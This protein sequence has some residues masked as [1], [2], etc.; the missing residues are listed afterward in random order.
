MIPTSCGHF[1]GYKEHGRFCSFCWIWRRF[2]N[3]NSFFN[4]RKDVE[5]EGEEE[6]DEGEPKDSVDL[7]G[8]DPVVPAGAIVQKIVG[9]IIRPAATSDDETADDD[10]SAEIEEKWMKK[11]AVAEKIDREYNDALARHHN[12]FDVANRIDI[13]ALNS[14]KNKQRKALP[15][16]I[17]GISNSIIILI[18]LRLAAKSWN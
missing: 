13:E 4:I 16:L 15:S 14:K 7:T 8:E 17:A 9:K 18:Y 5:E 1:C 12:K 2:L 6:E 10:K 11:K 3:Y